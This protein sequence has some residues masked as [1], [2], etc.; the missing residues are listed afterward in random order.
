[1]MAGGGAPTA[2]EQPIFLSTVINLPDLGVNNQSFRFGQ[3]TMD[4]DKYLSVKDNAA[5]GSPNW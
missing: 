1:M 2:T 5:D 3:L 4:S